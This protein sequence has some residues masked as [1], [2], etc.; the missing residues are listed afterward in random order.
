MNLVNRV[1]GIIVSPK[2]EWLVIATENHSMSTL[3]TSYVLPLALLSAAANFIGYGFLWADASIMWGVYFAISVAVSAIISVVVASYV[4]D[5]LAPT[6]GSEKNLNRSA[7]L[8]AYGATPGMVGGVFNIFPPIA[9]IGVLFALYGIYIW[10][11]GLT[12]VKKTPD[13]KRIGYIIVCFLALF[14][15]YFLIGLVFTMM[16]MPALGLSMLTAV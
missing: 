3:I 12:P 9:F 2:T 15:V 7:Q 6:F 14:V 8:V 16:L 11:L 4:V 13:D 1:K 10:Y 5:A